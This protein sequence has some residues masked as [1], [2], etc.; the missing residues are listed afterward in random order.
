MVDAETGQRGF[1]FSNQDEFLEPYNQ[2]I[3]EIDDL[4]DFVRDLT[5]DNAEQQQN[6]NELIP[7][8]QVKLTEVQTSIAL[9]RSGNEEL[10]LQ[11]F[12]SG[13]GKQAMDA[14]RMQIATMIELEETLLA[15]RNQDAR[16]VSQW[17]I[18]SLVAGTSVAIAL[19]AYILIVVG[20]AVILPIQKMADRIDQASGEIASTVKHQQKN[21][22]VQASVANQTSVTMDELSASSRKSAEQVKF[23]ATG[24]QQV[25]DLT[26]NGSRAVDRTLQGMEVL[27]TKVQAIADQIL[28]LSEKSGQIG[29]ISSLV[30]N[31][32]NQT[33]M[34]ALN[35]AVEAVRAGEHGKGFAVVAGEIRTLADRSKESIAKINSLTDEIQK[36]LRSTVMATEAGT[37][38][39]EQG[40]IIAAETAASF[41]QVN[42]AVNHITRSSQDIALNIAEQDQ[43]VQEVLKAMETLNQMAQESASGMNQVQVST[44]QLNLSSAQLRAIV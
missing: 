44:E 19:G 11:N 31:L 10:L 21:T 15:Q 36:S 41:A 25:L 4:I 12:V 26:E 29:E 17:A 6:I 39:V 43:A 38:T 1:L 42:E 32:A 2:S 13:R 34:L 3:D 16:R 27:R 20:R 33:N 37:Q 22:S 40:M 35:A 28:V 9:K 14:V 24:A 23:A 7:L 8:I 30:S 5:R 18:W